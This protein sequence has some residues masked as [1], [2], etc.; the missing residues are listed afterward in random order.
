MGEVSAFAPS[1]ITGIFTVKDGCKKPVFK[2]SRGAGV[3]LRKGVYTTVRLEKNHRWDVSVYL[4]GKPVNGKMTV[5]LATVKK[6]FR[7]ASP[8]KV[9]INHKVEVPIGAGYGVSGACAL[10]LSLALNEALNTGLSKVEAAQ[11]AHTA[12]IECKTGLGTV[13]AESFGGV[14]I[15][16][17]A[18]A[19]GIGSLKKIENVEK[20][21]VLSLCWGGLST[22]KFLRNEAF[23]RRVNMVGGVLLNK[24]IKNPSIDSLMFLSRRFAD[25]LNLYTL[26]LKKILAGLTELEEELR[27]F[28]MNMFGEAVFT[29][30][31][32]E[33][34]DEVTRRLKLFN[35]FGGQLI[36]SDIDNLGARIIG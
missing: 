26:R 14:E 23:K 28:S 6:F 7:L 5:S 19:P 4:N 3:S 35:S 24:L 18:G 8:N 12:E 30:I 9:L 13:L 17:E 15:R 27:P 10:S 25:R 11:I 1:H 32:R 34:L 21:M 20:F 22:K 31:E 33:R 2:G 36:V 16:V 29:L